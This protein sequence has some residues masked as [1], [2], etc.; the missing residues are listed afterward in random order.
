MR[1]AYVVAG[2]GAHDRTG[3]PEFT[4][5]AKRKF[6]GGEEFCETLDYIWLSE[7]WNVEGVRELPSRSALPLLYA[8]VSQLFV[9][10]RLVSNL[11]ACLPAPWP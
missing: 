4:N 7:E 9:R 11:L 6:S 3:E 2:G 10:A 1:S 5:F 8:P